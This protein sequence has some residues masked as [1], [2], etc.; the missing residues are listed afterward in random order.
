MTFWVGR[1]ARV[2][3]LGSW[4]LLLLTAKLSAEAGGEPRTFLVD[5]HHLELAREAWQSGDPIIAAD[6]SKLIQA[7]EESLSVGPYSVTF[8]P[9]VAPSGDPHDIVSYGFYWYP[10]PD[11]PDG[12]PWISRDGYGNVK[13]EMEWTDF[14]LLRLATWRLSLAYFFTKDERYAEKSAE[15]LRTWFLDAETRMNPRDEYSGMIPGV[16]PGS[17]NVPGFA[18]T[19]DRLI[20]AAGILEASPHWTTADKQGLQQWMWD[21]TEWAENSPQ[22]AA[23]RRE[24]S[25][26]GTNYDFLF[27]LISIYRE[28]LPLAEDALSALRA[29]SDARPDRRGRLIHLG[30]VSGQQPALPSLQSESCL[31]TSC[32]GCPSSGQP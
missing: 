23:Q 16:S 1:L 13:N 25:N 15:L 4:G 27:T 11:T 3:L 17:F 14:G 32:L 8:S 24:P 26:H 5:R 20:D 19:F 21:L 18:N 9:E 30:D 29:R 28:D 22:G 7:A 2:A 31:G 10:N 6:V 12:L